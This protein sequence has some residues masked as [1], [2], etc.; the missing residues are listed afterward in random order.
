[1]DDG[2]MT[3][4]ASA[5]WLRATVAGLPP[6]RGPETASSVTQQ[7]NAHPASQRVALT[8]V[9]RAIAVLHASGRPAQPLPRHLRAPLAAAL[10]ARTGIAPGRIVF[11]CGSDELI[12]LLCEIC[13]A[14]ATSSVIPAPSFPRYG[15]SA[16]I[17]GARAVR[18][19]LDAGGAN[20]P[21]TL[22]AGIGER[23]RLVFCCTPT[24][25]A[26]A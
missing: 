9:A 17:L 16:R 5:S 24:R 20:D 14:R 21:L 1:M 11:G 7:G 8:A 6:Y 13:S 19:G 15:H 22:A 23:T 18:A 26:A 2:S 25:R 3:P 10:A 12:H 4:Q